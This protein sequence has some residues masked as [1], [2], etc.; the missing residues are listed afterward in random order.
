MEPKTLTSQLL[1]LAFAWVR[2]KCAKNKLL[3]LQ[4]AND[5]GLQE[6]RQVKQECCEL[7]VQVHSLTEAFSVSLEASQDQRTQQS[8]ADF[9]QRMTSLEAERLTRECTELNLQLIVAREDNKAL[10]QD[11]VF[12][13]NRLGRLELDTGEIKARLV[14]LKLRCCEAANK[15]LYESSKSIS[16][17]S[18]AVVPATC[19]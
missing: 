19:L 16:K 2:V 12:T 10:A 18:Y 11:I 3:S 8:K 15:A 13:R 9:R 5:S 6:L 14:S 17:K 4:D 1:C 7:E